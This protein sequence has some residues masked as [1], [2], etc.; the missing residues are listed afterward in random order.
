MVHGSLGCQALQP[1]LTN[2]MGR[3]DVKGAGEASKC[4]DEDVIVPLTFAEN[5]NP[6]GDCHDLIL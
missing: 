2:I 4:L 1:A 5:Q 3:L 6:W